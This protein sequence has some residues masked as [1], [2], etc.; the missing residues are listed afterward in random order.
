MKALH[1]F[2]KVSALANWALKTFVFKGKEVCSER[3]PY[4]LSLAMRSDS[5]NIFWHLFKGCYEF[6][7][8]AASETQ[9]DHLLV[10]QLREQYDQETMSHYFIREIGFDQY[11]NLGLIC[12]VDYMARNDSSD[13]HHLVLNNDTWSKQIQD[14][15]LGL[16]LKVHSV[17]NYK[18][19]LL[20]LLRVVRCFLGMVKGY[21]LF[22]YFRLFRGK[23]VHSHSDKAKVGV[24]FAQPIGNDT[25]RRSDLFWLKESNIDPKDVIVYFVTPSKPPTEERIKYLKENG[26]QYVSLLKHK[27]NHGHSEVVPSAEFYRLKAECSKGALK[28]LFRLAKSVSGKNRKITLWQFERLGWLLNRMSTYEAF[29]KAYNI[30]MHFGFYGETDQN[31][32]AIHLVLKRLNGVDTYVHWSHHPMEQLWPSHHVYFTWGPYFKPFFEK[33]GHRMERLVYSGYAFDHKFHSVKEKARVLRQKLNDQ[34]VKFTLCFFDNAYHEGGWFSKKS[35]LGFYEG[36]LREVQSHP[37]WG[38]LIK[39]KRPDSLKVAME[40]DIPKLIKSLEDSGRC[41]ILDQSELPTTVAQASDLAIGFGVFCSPA[42][43]TSLSGVPTVTF[44]PTNENTHPF[45]ETGFNKIVFNDLDEFLKCVKYFAKGKQNAE[46]IADF[47]KVL[48]E[49]DPFQDHQSAQRIGSY[50]KVLLDQ[51]SSGHNAEDAMSE[52]DAFYRSH[53]GDDKVVVYNKS[54]QSNTEKAVLVA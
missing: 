54:N 2:G 11:R 6:G 21:V 25:N 51:L 34:G 41:M 13:E 22:G 30:R 27:L 3:K 48:P 36:L 1:Y 8:K 14:Y 31:L 17:K 35:L 53:Y 26:V 46:G 45:Y 28:I 24:Y 33:M 37:D 39:P 44:D 50:M 49:I 32:A 29:F 43:E 12:I 10:D 5:G 16:A 23:Q 4:D 40:G 19:P 18:L 9:A 42:I 47:S 7:M 15:V 20:A 38:I 52:A